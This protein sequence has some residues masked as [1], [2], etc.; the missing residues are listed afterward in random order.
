M[1]ND[2]GWIPPGFDGTPGVMASWK[3]QQDDY[4]AVA[5]TTTFYRNQIAP[6]LASPYIE[7]FGAAK[8]LLDAGELGAAVV[9]AQTACEVLGANV[10][11]RL[12][13]K[14]NVEFL[15]DWIVSA[16]TRGNAN[17][18]NDRVRDLYVTLSGDRIQDQPFWAQYQSHVR[19]RHDVA[20]NGT[21]VSKA[22]TE[23]SYQAAESFIRHLEGVIVTQGL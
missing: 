23:E 22:E 9:L 8:R 6:L 15:R 11:E 12:M 16:A 17:F 19:R 13:K 1:T 5:R 7:L 21:T 4:Y 20:H 14:R 10:L 3:K 18:S 2:V